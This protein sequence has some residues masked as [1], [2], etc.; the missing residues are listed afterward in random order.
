M[1]SNRLGQ[2][3]ISVAGRR[4]GARLA[5]VLSLAAGSAALAIAQIRTGITLV[6]VDVRVVDRDGNP[7]TDLT[8]IVDDA[9][10]EQLIQ[11]IERLNLELS[12]VEYGRTVK[13]RKEALEASLNI[14]VKGKPEFVRTVV[15]RVRVE[16]VLFGFDTSPAVAVTSLRW[17]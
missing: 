4:R 16:L 2:I 6:P 9:K 14:N 17:S 11:K 5:L 10:G 7:V 3:P 15:F 13:A 12:T 8:V 1:R